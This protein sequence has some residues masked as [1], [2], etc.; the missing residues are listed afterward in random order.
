MTD[1]PVVSA[2]GLVHRYGDRL[3]L[4]SFTLEVPE[5]SVFGVLGPNGSGKTTF[6]SL[7]AAMQTPQEGSLHVFGQPPSPALRSRVGTVFQE[8]ALDP[9]MTPAEH[10]ALAGRMFGLD[11]AAVKTRSAS[12][13]AHFGLAG[14]E[15][16]RISNL[17]GGMRRRLEMARA[18][19]HAP[20][21]LV[22]DE[23]TTGVDADERAVLWEQLRDRGATILLATNDLAEADHVCDVV[24]F[25]RD[26]HVVASGTPSSLKE[27]LRRDSVRIGWAG[28]PPATVEDLGSWLGVGTAVE[29]AGEVIVT[30]D[31]ASSF[32]P[33]L[34]ARWPGAIRSVAVEQ[35]SLEDAYFHHVGRRQR[36]DA[37]GGG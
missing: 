9:L 27:G 34:F 18:L 6:V 37:E 17:S 7:V 22:L 32:V 11:R 20:G 30:V 24:A 8:N 4:D 12:L 28:E 14:R 5:G 35:A 26:G 21:L 36:N 15:R 25:V 16:E 1:A 3:A 19:L 29:R 31:D 33:H 2:Q 10:L 23:P 13:L